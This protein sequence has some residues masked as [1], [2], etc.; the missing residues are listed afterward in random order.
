M[1]RAIRV[2]RLERS[3]RHREEPVDLRKSP[4]YPVDAPADFSWIDSLGKAHGGEGHLRDISVGGVFLLTPTPPP[5]GALVRLRIALPL[6]PDAVSGMRME[7]E[8]RVLRV[9]LPD[10][11]SDRRGFAA[12]TES[13]I[14]QEQ[15]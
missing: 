9:E 7:A 12:L 4:R 14:L 8:T 3:F 1:Q 11:V 15:D 5:P 10:P 2:E 6:L 13:F